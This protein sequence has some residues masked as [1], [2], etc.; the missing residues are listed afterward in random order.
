MSTDPSLPWGIL[1][2][3][4]GYRGP[5]ERIMYTRRLA[6]KSTFFALAGQGD[7]FP[8][9]LRGWRLQGSGYPA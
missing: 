6:K 5:T 7:F 2:S 8:E 9:I 4:S 3:L 1:T